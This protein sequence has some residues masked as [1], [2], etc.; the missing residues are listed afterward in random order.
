MS[1]HKQACLALRGDF[2]IGSS[3]LVEL[4]H[5]RSKRGQIISHDVTP[6]ND[7]PAFYR[8]RL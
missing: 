4:H 2:D 5:R 6:S 3:G 7:M 1:M 8:N